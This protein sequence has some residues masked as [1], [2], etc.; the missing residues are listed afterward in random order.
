MGESNH[1][2]P[3]HE[4]TTIRANGFVIKVKNYFIRENANCTVFL[5]NEKIFVKVTVTD[6]RIDEY[7]SL[8]TRKCESEQSA[9]IAWLFRNNRYEELN[10]KRMQEV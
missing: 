2:N 1:N 4:V 9:P 10:H 7:E 6:G 3:D 8:P 5:H